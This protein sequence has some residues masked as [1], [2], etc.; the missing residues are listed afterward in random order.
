MTTLK[1][2]TVIIPA[3]NRPKHLRRLLDYYSQTDLEIIIPDSSDQIFPLIKD[4]PKLN[5][6]LDPNYTSC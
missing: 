5:I 1:K 2:A 6:Y 3:H 4:Y